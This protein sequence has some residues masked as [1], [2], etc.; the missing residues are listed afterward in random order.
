MLKGCF[1]L[2]PKSDGGAQ[3]TGADPNLVGVLPLEPRPTKPECRRKFVQVKHPKAAEFLCPANHFPVDLALS[4]GG[5]ILGGPKESSL[6][7][8][9][10]L[11]GARGYGKRS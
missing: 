2:I 7:L 5:D 10:E 6:D 8:V 4:P 3:V 11:E 9:Y 1:L